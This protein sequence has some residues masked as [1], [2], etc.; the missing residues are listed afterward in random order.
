[1]IKAILISYAT[2]FHGYLAGIFREIWAMTQ[3]FAGHFHNITL[4]IN[5]KK[6]EEENGTKNGWLNP[7]G[8]HLTL[9]QLIADQLHYLITYPSGIIILFTLLHSGVFFF[10]S[11]TFLTTYPTGKRR[12]THWYCTVSLRSY[13]SN[14]ALFYLVI[15]T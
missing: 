15:A 7:V 11:D 3:C 4:A 2:T 10:P 8:S 5:Y 12:K 13:F 9:I 14:Q 6:D 1:M